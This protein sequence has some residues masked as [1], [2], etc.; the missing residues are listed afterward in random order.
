MDKDR[1]ARI[2]NAAIESRIFHIRGQK[3]M[4][5]DADYRRRWIL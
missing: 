4:L 2:T 3:V 5:D 1:P